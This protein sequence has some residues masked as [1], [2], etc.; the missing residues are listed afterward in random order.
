MIAMLVA[1]VWLPVGPA[2]AAEAKN[3]IGKPVKAL[4][5][6]RLGS[7]E[8][9]IVDVEGERVVYVIVHGAERF[10]TLPL[11][12]LDERLRLN[13]E[14]A[15]A[16]ARDASPQDAQFRRAAKLIGQPVEQP[17]GPR[18]GTI[19]DIDF[20]LASGR[21]E[22]VLVTTSEGLRYMP[23]AVLA[24]G[25]FPPLTRWQAEHPP[26]DV[27]DRQGFVRREASDERKR[28]H[29]HKW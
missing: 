17:G 1:A 3:L 29:H 26:A 28:L 2:H 9:L 8:D 16:L 4:D 22:Q 27:H 14:L 6:E 21:V 23:A 19:T 12:A 7:V 18:I 15:N 13:M 5:G 25:H 20:D 11:R 10:Y 24:Q